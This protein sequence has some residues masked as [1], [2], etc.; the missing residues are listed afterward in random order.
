MQC[1]TFP[2]KP[3]AGDVGRLIRVKLLQQQEQRH[4]GPTALVHADGGMFHHLPFV[5]QLGTSINFH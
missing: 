2:V 3:L 1:Y 5:V 4:A